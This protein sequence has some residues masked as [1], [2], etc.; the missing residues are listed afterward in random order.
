MLTIAGLVIGV[1]A[2]LGLTGL[3]AN[4]LYGVTPMD[5]AM[6]GAV[7]LVLITVAAVACYI[8][9]RRAYSTD[10]LQTL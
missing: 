8:P 6:L 1:A 10:P 7:A 9:S 2:A 5:P 4:Q 3:I